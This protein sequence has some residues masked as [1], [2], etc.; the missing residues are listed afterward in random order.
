MHIGL[1]YYKGWKAELADPQCTSK[2]QH[3]SLHN[4]RLCPLSLSS[5]HSPTAKKFYLPLLQVVQP[6]CS[7]RQRWRKIR[8]HTHINRP[9]STPYYSK[10]KHEYSLILNYWLIAWLIMHFYLNCLCHLLAKHQYFPYVLI[11]VI[12]WCALSQTVRLWTRAYVNPKFVRCSAYPKLLLT[13]VVNQSPDWEQEQSWHILPA[14]LNPRGGTLVRCE[15]FR[16][17]SGTTAHIT[18]K[19]YYQIRWL[20]MT[21]ISVRG[22]KWIVIHE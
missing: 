3:I 4:N 20:L 7:W 14:Q 17:I 1:D 10:H 21:F 19:P 22:R 15:R 11:L 13:F 5:L 9:P 6:H 8:L 2:V 18:M 16:P 12:T